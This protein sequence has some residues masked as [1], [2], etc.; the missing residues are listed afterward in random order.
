MITLERDVG[1]LGWVRDAHERLQPN[2]S[3]ASALGHHPDGLHIS[4]LQE[5]GHGDPLERSDRSNFNKIPRLLQTGEGRLSD[6]LVRAF[7]G[8]VSQADDRP[9]SNTLVF[10][11]ARN[12][13]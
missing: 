10:I 6:G 4:Q 12:C 8:Q 3:V 13:Q 2:G 9:G 7:K 5:R 1:E 11:I